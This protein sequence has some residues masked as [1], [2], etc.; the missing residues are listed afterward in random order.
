MEGL[1]S[2]RPVLRVY[3]GDKLVRVEEFMLEDAEA[4]LAVTGGAATPEGLPS[5]S[6]RWTTSTTSSGDSRV[7]PPWCRVERRSTGPMNSS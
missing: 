6:S 5:C 7:W 1:D 4:R 2:P 3:E